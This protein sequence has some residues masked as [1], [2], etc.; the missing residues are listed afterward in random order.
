MSL[1]VAKEDG[2]IKKS[3]TKELSVFTTV[4]SQLQKL[5]LFTQT[6]H[7]QKFI[8]ITLTNRIPCFVILVMV[9]QQLFI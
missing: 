3:E 9:L 4:R 8:S 5:Q 1:Y 2:S 6:I 7:L